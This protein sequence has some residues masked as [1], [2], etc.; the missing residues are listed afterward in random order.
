MKRFFLLLFLPVA[1]N[2]QKQK[3]TWE[4]DTIFSNAKPYAIMTSTGGLQAVYSIRTLTNK[5]IAIASYDATIAEDANKNT[6]YR[7]TFSGDGAYGH[8][9]NTLGLG[10]RLA[11]VIVENDLVHDSVA[12]AEGEK[13]FLA[14]YPARLPGNN[15]ATVVIVN[16]NTTNN[17][18]YTP[19]ERNRN[20]TIFVNGTDISQDFKT[21]GSVTSQ[22]SMGGGHSYTTL[23]YTLPNG[24]KVAEAT[25]TDYKYNTCTVV[26]LKDNA[27]HT[28]Q[29]TNSAAKEKEVV[30]WLVKNY[31]L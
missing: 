2:A 15:P 24:V 3:V 23:S 11:K 26:T 12:N 13:R 25:F 4:N 22:N 9:P 16:N 30:E 27:T 17:T 8:F 20:A 19:V 21:I 7:V 14:I 31:Y 5:E 28:I 1:L 29:L 18:N 10:K 6:Y